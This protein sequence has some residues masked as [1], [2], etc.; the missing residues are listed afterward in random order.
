MSASPVFLVTPKRHGDH[1]GWFIESY[2]QAS[3]SELAPVV[4]VQDNHSMSLERGTLRGLH[5]QLPP[6]AQ[7]KLVRCSRGSIFDVAVDIRRGSPTYGHWVGAELSAEN[8][9]Q[10]FVPKGFAHGFVTLEEATEVQ[11]KCTD[12]YAPTAD[13][14]LRWND[15]QID[16]GWPLDGDTGP[17]LSEKDEKQPF[18]AD[19]D[20]PF[21]YDGRPLTALA[22]E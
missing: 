5:F 1:R 12:F 4:F 22:T 8:G 3:F 21:D 13:S 7:D 9:R 19:F 10:L 11:Y 6:H 15:P 2:N 18:L 16:I 14:G 20:S 17:H